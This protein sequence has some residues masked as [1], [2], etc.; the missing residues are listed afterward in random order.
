[1]IFFSLWILKNNVN[2]NTISLEH[3]RNTFTI[4]KLWLMYTAIYMSPKQWPVSKVW[5]SIVSRPRKNVVLIFIKLI[6]SLI[7]SFEYGRI[8]RHTSWH[9]LYRLY[10]CDQHKGYTVT[11]W[12]LWEARFK[13]TKLVLAEIL[14]ISKNNFSKRWLPDLSN[15]FFFYIN[16][17]YFH[18]F[19]S[20][21]L[22]LNK[23]FH[24]HLNIC[25]VGTCRWYI[26]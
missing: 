2:L 13:L 24:I 5:D 25:F 19:M 17:I 18:R 10:S 22:F 9:L 12:L 7:L 15:V 1:M 16:L 11:G 21:I 8:T 26:L 23:L 3:H 4:L 6:A 14:F 20:D